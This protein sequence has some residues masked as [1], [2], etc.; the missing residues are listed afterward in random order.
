MVD[1]IAELIKMTLNVLYAHEATWK[2]MDD[3][4]YP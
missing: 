3:A 2:W 1:I 4:V